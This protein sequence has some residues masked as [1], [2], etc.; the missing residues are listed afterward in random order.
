VKRKRISRD[1]FQRWR[2]SARDSG[3]NEEMDKMGIMPPTGSELSEECPICRGNILQ[4]GRDLSGAHI[5]RFSV[6]GCRHWMWVH[7]K[8]L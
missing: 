2:E 8:I 6:L 4:G 7:D 5:E 3:A 1:L